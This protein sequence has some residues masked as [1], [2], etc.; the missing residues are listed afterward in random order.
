MNQ[1]HTEA[2]AAIAKSL[3]LRDTAAPVARISR[4]ALIIAGAVVSTGLFVAVGWSLAE[5]HRAAPRA[6]DAPSVVTPS[7]RVTALPKGYSGPAG[8]PAL[9]PPLPG[10]LG[11]PMLSAQQQGKAIDWP[12]SAERPSPESQAVTPSVS[13][14]TPVDESAQLHQAVRQ[15]A[16]QSG[17]FVAEA[18]ARSRDVVPA[19]VQSAA[20]AGAGEDPRITSAERLQP[21]ASPYI[22]QAGAIIPAAL[23]TGLRSDAPGVAIAQVTQDVHDSLGDGVLLIPAGSRLVGAYDAEIQSGQSRLRVSW[24]RLILP[25]GRSIVLDKLP[26]ADEQGMAGLQD[27]VDRH[28]GRILAAAAIS[29]LLAIGAESGASSDESDVVR[30]LR[31]GGADAVSDVGRQIVG[32]SLEQAPT[33]TI[34]PGAPLRVLLTKDLVLEPYRAGAR[35]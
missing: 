33:L 28:S 10:D 29:T 23:V 27:G 15:G 12:Q 1:D 17:L 7:E 20:Q 25:S 35:P 22:L 24:T 5:R 3:R 6:D 14:V 19:A 32:R 4:R 18:T 16:R 21:P 8:V 11:R 30:A 31:R 9:G 2:E 13:Q 34:R 26:G